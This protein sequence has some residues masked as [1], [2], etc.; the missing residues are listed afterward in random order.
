[1]ALKMDY[2]EITQ[3][4][5]EKNENKLKRTYRCYRKPIK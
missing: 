5:T 3:N 4:N 2:S 1:M